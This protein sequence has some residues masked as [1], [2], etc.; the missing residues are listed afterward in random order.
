MSNKM[1]R[2]WAMLLAV[3]MTIALAM[4]TL[5]AE[6]A[7]NKIFIV[8]T[9]DVHSRIDVEQFVAT[10]AKEKGPNVLVLSAGD[11]LHGQPFAT[12]SRGESVVKVMNTVGYDAMAPGN[13]EFNY[14]LDRLVELSKEMKFPLLAANVLDKATGK[15]VF[16]T[17]VIKDVAGVKVGIFG[18]TTPETTVKTDPRNVASVDFIAPAKTAAS[19]VN[20]LKEKGADVIIA[21]VHLGLDEE[22]K[23]E[24]RSSYLAKNVPG[25]DLIVD[26]HSHTVLK[27]GQAEGDTMIVQTGSYGDSIGLTELTLKDKKVVA[28]KE[29]LIEKPQDNGVAADEAVKAE[30]D[31]VKKANEEITKVVIGKTPVDLQGERGDVRTKETNLSDLINDA[32]IHAT[33]ADIAI[34]NGGNIRATIKAGDITK[35]DILTVLPFGNIIITKDI[36]G[37]NILEALELGF[38]A[39]PET[40]GGFT[41]VA[42]VKVTF[43]PAKE[44]GSRITNIVMENGA[45]FDKEKTYKLVTNDFLAAG[46]DGYTMLVGNEGYTEYAAMDEMVI[47][48]IATNPAI[49]E[50][51]KGR[52][53]VAEAALAPAPAAPAAPAPAAQSSK[54]KTYVVVTGDFLW[55]IAQKFGT[56][57]EE[58]AKINKLENPN[59]IYPNQ[60]I[61]LP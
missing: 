54:E 57:W 31:V 23:E 58:L 41:H 21:L 39:Y 9:N 25:I 30:I 15:N 4:P 43:D 20:E 47:D 32:L 2:L 50:G 61:V 18:L 3:V 49:Q 44:K 46:G 12:I 17:Y 22:T 27:E 59:M 51:T 56:T 37:A 55:K 7:E 42:G 11:A 34:T 52:M 26:G 36:K 45:P 28:K 29:S 35:G 53:V 24:E 38:S 6:A 14:G 8:H 33:G 19:M 5:A 40:A 60:V 13:H 1:R 48:Y 16:S 10:I